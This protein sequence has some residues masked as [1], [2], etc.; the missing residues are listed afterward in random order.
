MLPVGDDIARPRA[1]ALA[2]A[3]GAAGAAAAAVTLLRGNGWTALAFA[4]AAL[5]TVAYGSSLEATFG[6]ARFL[7]T[8]AS[9]AVGG[10]LIAVSAFGDARVI[11]AAA[12]GATSSVVATHLVAHRGARILTLQLVPPFTGFVAVPAWAWAIG[13]GAIVATLAALGAFRVA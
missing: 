11:A 12:A 5:W 9:G 6:R 2:P 10:A 4:C 13:W 8:F 7:L 1:P 3:L